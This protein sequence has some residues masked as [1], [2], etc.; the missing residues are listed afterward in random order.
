MHSIGCIFCLYFQDYLQLGP[1]ELKLLSVRGHQMSFYRQSTLTDEEEEARQ[2]KPY[3]WPLT[4][5]MI[6]KVTVPK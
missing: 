6:H 1:L 3:D 4:K 2:Y 5:P